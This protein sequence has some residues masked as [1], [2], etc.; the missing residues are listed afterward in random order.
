MT[1][2]EF[3]QK[4]DD[5]EDITEMLDL[6]K[7]K[8]PLSAQKKVSIELPIWMIELIDQEANRLGVTPQTIIQT[9]LAE[10]LAV[11]NPS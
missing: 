5:G 3:D 8:R 7:A 1:A 9:F 10:H 2:K 6:S 11:N 4:F